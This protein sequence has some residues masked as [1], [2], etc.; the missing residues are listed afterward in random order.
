[1]VMFMVTAVEGGGKKER[2]RERE[3]RLSSSS[4]ITVE[5]SRWGDTITGH[6]DV[7]YFHEYI[8]SHPLSSL[9]FKI[10]DSRLI[11]T[12]PGMVAERDI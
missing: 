5:I 6:F 9:D 12:V 8:F 7:T 1:M 10:N 2:G 4:L 11:N 3:S